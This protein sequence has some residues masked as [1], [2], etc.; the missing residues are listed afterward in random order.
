M[1]IE[2]NK[3]LK[4]PSKEKSNEI[5][6]R[7]ILAL[8]QVV[9][10]LISLWAIFAY[11]SLVWVP[12]VL[13]MFFLMKCVGVTITYHRILSHST[14][15]M[16]PIVE[17]VCTFLGLHGTYS[18]PIDFAAGHTL[19]HKHADTPKDPHGPH[20]MGWKVVFPIFWD[21]GGPTGG[22]LRT[23]VRLMRNKITLFFHRN[24]WILL[25]IPYLLLLFSPQLFFFGYFVPATLSIWASA[26]AV[27][28]HD[29]DG[30]VN[31]GFLYGVVTGGEHAHL[32][33]HTNPGDTS[34][35]GW[36]NTVA[37]FIAKKRG[38]L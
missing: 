10:P 31:K 12:V 7:Y 2:N 19:H 13:V 37:T 24:F 25:P 20:H 14:H 21:T 22:D 35:E 3:N 1:L 29:E 9:G 5:D 30:P 17:A 6:K 28:N 4:M 8:M 33:H 26:Y 32:W 16:N 38:A 27:F 15:K 34:G 11:G 23:V 18:S 36:L